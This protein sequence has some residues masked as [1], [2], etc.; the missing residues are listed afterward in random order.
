MSYSSKWKTGLTLT[1][2]LLIAAAVGA[3]SVAY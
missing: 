1:A 2:M 3:C